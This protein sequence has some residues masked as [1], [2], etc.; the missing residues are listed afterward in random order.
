MNKIEDIEKIGERIRDLRKRRSMTIQQLAQY[1]SLSIG[2]LSNIERNQTSPTLR[3][4]NT[5][6]T[7]MDVSLMDI[8]NTNEE[9]KLFMPK[10]EQT[11]RDYPELKQQVRMFD[12]GRHSDFYEYIIYYAGKCQIVE[13]VHTFPE[14]CT[15][16]KGELHITTDGNTYVLQEGDALYIKARSPHI[17]VNKGKEDC[18]T[19]WHHQKK[20]R[21]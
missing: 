3:D 17:V 10:E 4:L 5:I 8:I 18:V 2:H 11:V 15:V 7:A 21:N 13:N 12:F 6:C 16:L 19:F 14:M 20:I 9:E 1:T